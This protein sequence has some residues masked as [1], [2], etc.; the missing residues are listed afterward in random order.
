LR[1]LSRSLAPSLRLRVGLVAFLLLLVGLGAL[2]AYAAASENAL[3]EDSARANYMDYARGL[4]I[5]LSEHVAHSDRERIADHIRAAMDAG[6]GNIRYIS[7]ED[8]WGKPYAVAGN[9]PPDGGPI[10]GESARDLKRPPLSFLR[11]GGYEF[12]LA[13]PMVQDGIRVGIVRMGISTHRMSAA[14]TSFVRTVIVT[15]GLGVLVFAGLALYVD[16]R[17]RHILSRF[18]QATRR[19]AGGDLERPVEIRTGDDLE[20]LARNFNRMAASLRE[21]EADLQ[22]A[23]ET[24]EG[25]VRERTRELT[26]EKERLDTIVGAVGAGMLLL[27]PSMRVIWANRMA[28]EWLGEGSLRVG[29]PCPWQGPAG[30]PV[31]ASCPSAIAAATGRTEVA[32]AVAVEVDG[33]RRHFTVISSPILDPEGR[34]AEVLELILDVTRRKEIEEELV[35]AAK[36]ASLGELAGGVAHEI[37]NP[38]AIISAK[39]KL[40]LATIRAGRTPER[41]ESDIEK[42]ERHSER[43]GRISRSLLSYSRRSPGE[44]KVVRLGDVVREA[45]TLLEHRFAVGNV[46]VTLRVPEDLPP[47]LACRNDLVQVFVNLV[48]NAIDAM[49]R[50]GE[51]RIEA[52]ERQGVLHVLVS[53][54]GTGMTDAVRRRLFSP[55]FTTKD[56]GMGTGLGLSI[57][58]RILRDHGGEVAVESRPG[59]GTTF[60]IRLPA[61]KEAAHA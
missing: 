11:G 30:T 61:A 59:V 15:V 48:Q 22:R 4:A 27:D 13:V 1:F 36:L 21:R 9:A 16:A 44:R 14:V 35:Q 56:P 10:L 26:A 3:V 6:D 49:P 46:R 40:L 7:V 23:K 38:V 39:A 31:C 19:M 54:T 57:S 55:F 58:Q 2:V 8:V 50:G 5:M 53:D 28:R 45:L 17:L 24:L 25:T 37:G 42:I 41:L 18:I 47:V 52:G 32:D 60:S 43:I 33:V 51:V 29:S 20:E 12:E 34:V